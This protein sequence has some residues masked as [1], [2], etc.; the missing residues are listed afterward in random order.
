VGG[1]NIYPIT[2][3]DIKKT[4]D[5]YFSTFN[6]KNIGFVMNNIDILS[7]QG[8]EVCKMFKYNSNGKDI[9]FN[10]KITK[11]Q[12]IQNPHAFHAYH[13]QAVLLSENSEITNTDDVFQAANEKIM[14]HGT[15]TTNPI[16]IIGGADGLD[17]RYSDYGFYGRANYTSENSSYVHNNSYRFDTSDK[18]AQMLMVRVLAGKIYDIPSRKEEHKK[19]KHPPSGY[20]SVRGYVTESDVAIMVYETKMAYP[21]YLITYEK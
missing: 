4:G 13:K 18:E 9:C 19:L 6:N 12:E 15:K 8:E 7:K 20:N 16:D 11:I 1:R 3:K 10:K 2:W 21:S 5:E 14:K 17:F